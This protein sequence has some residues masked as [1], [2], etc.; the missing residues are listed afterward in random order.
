MKDQNKTKA[1]LISELEEMRKRVS[2]LERFESKN[3]M[4]DEKFRIIFDYAPDAY[5][6]NDLRGRFV[7][8]NKAAERITGYRKGEL[9]GKSF[10]QL[11]IL[12][13][14]QIPKVTTALARN[15]LGESTGADEITLIRK[16]GSKVDVEVST[17]TVKIGGETLVL[18]IAREIT[19]RKKA[20]N[21]LRESEEKYRGLVEQSLQG[22][23]IAQNNP[24]RISFASKP[25]QEITGFSTEMLESFGP[26]K[27]IKLIHP[28]D[29]KRFFENFR[30]RLQGKKVAQRQEY[31]II[32]KSGDIRHVEIFC[33]LTEYDGSPATQTAFYDIT[34]RVR[35]EE[36]LRK[37]EIFNQTL[38]DTSPDI[39]YVYDII[40]K[41]LIYSNRGIT[42]ILGYTVEEIQAMGENPISKLMHPDDF[43]IYLSEILPRYQSMRDGETVRHKYRMKHEDGMW[44]W[45]QSKESVFTR[46]DDGTPQQIFGLSFD[47]TKRVRSIQAL[48]ESQAHY[49]QLFDLLPYGGEV[50]DTEG[51]IIDCSL[52]TS[53]MLGYQMDE[54]IGKQITNFVD[55][56]TA[57]IF[58]QN[59]PRV[60]K[61]ESLFL[62]GIMVHKNGCKINVLRAA[63]PII[64]A[65]KEVEGMLALSVDITDRVR[66]EEEKRQME[67]HLRQQQKLE[68]IGTLASGVAHEINNPIMGIMNYAQ[69]IHDRIDPAEGRL[70]EFSAGIIHETERVAKIVRN[71][72]TFSRQEKQSHSLARMTDIVEDTLTL[73][74]T[75]IKR[76]QITL[77][78]AVPEDLP[79]IQCRSQQ[80]QQV[81]MNLLTNARDALNQRYPE[82]DPDKIVSVTVH[83]F[84][85]DGRRWLRTAVEDHGVGVPVEIRERIFDPFFTTKDRAT[86]TGLGLSIS[87]GIVQ[88]HH[89]ELTF[90]SEEGQPTRFYLDL[91]VDNGWE[92]EE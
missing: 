44:R 35:A 2:K 56:A 57:K 46:Q 37:S 61:G 79:K 32:H 43:K 23:I 85:K 4:V 51:R 28:D 16:D 60:L 24:V 15:A 47:I 6:L 29:R 78:V 84:E 90:E 73:I 68:S 49:R 59:F 33:S 1:K 42:N 62:E 74:R 5:Y 58:K 48:K 36:A 17:H 3:W 63:Q 40:N 66:M 87:L 8:G 34:E 86:G 52:N 21:K 53:R 82:Y 70:R 14:N 92:L 67:A 22:L 50:I 83:L 38:L 9:I 26:Q 30:N 81:L 72:L 20:E 39:I 64:N 91:P 7:D 65:D 71:L 12:P 76:D 88:D 54:L 18:G 27:L 75:I 45:L 89:G 69:L 77:E 10:L 31:K 80:I 13:K 25:M 41:K 11:N 55:E 19:E